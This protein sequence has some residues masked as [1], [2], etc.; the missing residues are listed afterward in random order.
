MKRRCVLA[1]ARLRS[2]L[3]DAVE[4]GEAVAVAAAEKISHEAILHGLPEVATARLGQ[5]FRIVQVKFT[6]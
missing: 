2:C 5:L 4:T 3:D 1:E 6:G